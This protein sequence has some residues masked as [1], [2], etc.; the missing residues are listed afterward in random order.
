V[1]R[2]YFRYCHAGIRATNIDQSVKLRKKDL[3]S[4]L[5]DNASG[6]AAGRRA[7]AISKVLGGLFGTFASWHLARKGKVGER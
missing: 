7:T 4:H 5:L 1:H 3:T 6:P 2:K